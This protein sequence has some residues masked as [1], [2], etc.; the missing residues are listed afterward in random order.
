MRQNGENEMIEILLFIIALPVIL[1]YLL[2]WALVLLQWLVVAV[3]APFVLLEW[4]L[5]E[6][7]KKKAAAGKPSM[8]LNVLEFGLIGVFILSVVMTVLQ[9]V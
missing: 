5:E 7:E 2:P 9:Y 6:M 3:F 4:K 8:A 1:K